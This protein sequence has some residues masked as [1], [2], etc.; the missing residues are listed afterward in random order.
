MVT[1]P[2][3][4]EG[5][6]GQR[7]GHAAPAQYRGQATRTYGSSGSA[8]GQRHRANVPH[9]GVTALPNV[10][11]TSYRPP[12]LSRWVV[13]ARGKERRLPSLAGRCGGAVACSLQVEVGAEL[14]VCAVLAPTVRTQRTRTIRTERDDPFVLENRE[15]DSG[16]PRHEWAAIAARRPSISARTTRIRIAPTTL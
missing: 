15:I 8:G 12:L 1:Q 4:D 13:A 9:P 11:P 6:E 2:Q 10:G 3:R 14:A 16:P 7:E 5:R